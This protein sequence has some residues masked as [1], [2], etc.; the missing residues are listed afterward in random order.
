M[1]CP[2]CTSEMDPGKAY[3]RGTALGFLLVGLSH[4]H[5]WFEFQ[6]TGR[7]KMIVRSRSG[8]TT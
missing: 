1:K 5:C 2:T 7:K 3:I 8:L 4:Q 6:T